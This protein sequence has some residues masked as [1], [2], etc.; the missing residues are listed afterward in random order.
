EFRRVLFRSWREGEGARDVNRSPELFEAAVEARHRH[1]LGEVA[2]SHERHRLVVRMREALRFALTAIGHVAHRAGFQE[3][4]DDSCSQGACSARHDHVSIPI[5]H[6]LSPS[7][8]RSKSLGQ[9]C[10]YNTY[11][12]LATRITPAHAW[13]VTFVGITMDRKE[14]VLLW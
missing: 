1:L 4:A 12:A 3:R 2:E 13:M 5:V 6:E 9:V 8:R 14:R 10:R 7:S 11:R